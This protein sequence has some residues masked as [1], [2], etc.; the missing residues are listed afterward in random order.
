MTSKDTYRYDKVTMSILMRDFVFDKNSPND[1]N[2]VPHFELKD[3]EG[4]TISNADLFDGRPTLLTFGSRTCPMTV[5][6]V[7]PLKTLYGE[8]GDEVQFVTVNVRE[9]HPAEQIR[10]PGSM[11]KKMEHARA[12]KAELEL[13]WTV[14]TDD[15]EGSFHRGMDPKPNSSYVVGPTGRILFRSLWASDIRALRRAL[16]NVTEGRSPTKKQS[17]RTFGP[18]LRGLGYFHHTLRNAGPQAMRDMLLAAPPIAILGR[19]A[20]TFRRLAP[21][22]R[23]VPAL[24]TLIGVVGA[25]VGTVAAVLV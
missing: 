11:A 19:I 15:L 23:G 4:E 17:T 21:D 12:M 18:L 22:H 24:L 25:I 9:A 13:P 16:Q 3:L 14:L 8:F 2:V 10:Q 7:D 1:D 6:S 5:S 20:G